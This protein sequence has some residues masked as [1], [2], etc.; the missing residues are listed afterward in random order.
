MNTVNNEMK[1]ENL[2]LARNIRCEEYKKAHGELRNCVATVIGQ[3][4]AASGV[5]GYKFSVPEWGDFETL[6]L[7]NEEGRHN[8]DLNFRRDYDF[9]THSYAEKR[10]LEINPCTMGGFKRDDF[11]KIAYYALSG[12]LALHLGEIEDALNAL[13]WTAFEKARENLRFANGEI[14][15]LE[16]DI[17]QANNARKTAEAEK[18]LV[19][20]TE[21]AVGFTTRWDCENHKDVRTGIVTKKVEKMTAKL[22]WF[23]NDW[24][25]YKKAEVIQHLVGGIEARGWSFAA[26]V[27]KSGF[28]AK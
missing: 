26:D 15:Q 2:V 10:E 5:T 22:V 6:R 3:F 28:A 9:S 20:G 7:E 12:Y 8:I 24:H 11:G 25:Q 4:V 17:I 1:M 18:R 27:D 16:H 21:L 14:E 13:D 23:E 19:V